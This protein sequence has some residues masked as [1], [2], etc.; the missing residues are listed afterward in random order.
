MRRPAA[1]ALA[2]ALLL[3]VGAASASP[4]A[5]PYA[6]EGINHMGVPQ[7][8]E[9]LFNQLMGAFTAMASGQD[10]VV[11]SAAPANVTPQAFAKM[12]GTILATVARSSYNT[13]SLGDP[14]MF[15]YPDGRVAL[16]RMPKY[17]KARCTCIF[18]HGC[19]HD[20]YSWFYKTPKCPQCTGLPEEV[21]HSKQCLAN[22]CAVLALMSLNRDYRSRCFASSGSGN[23]QPSAAQ[24][25]KYWASKAGMTKKPMYMF[26]ISSG[27][28]FAIKFPGTMKIQGVVSEVNMPW[29]KS[30]GATNGH[31]KLRYSFPPTV[32]YMMKRDLETK[33]QIEQ[34]LVIFKNNRV[35]ADY[36]Y[37]DS[38]P[39]TPDWLS[40]RSVYI[41]PSQSA[42]IQKYLYKIKVLDADGNVRYDVRV[43]RG[44]ILQ[45]P[46]YLPWLKRTDP[47]YNL[48]SDESQIWQELNLAWS[49]HEIVSDPV[50]A[51][52]KWLFAK[53]KADLGS[54]V[55]KYDWNQNIAC[56]SETRIGC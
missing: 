31:G 54:L 17:T 36:V 29:E 13:E 39:V 18:V 51:T 44:W 4:V 9:Q 56:L 45:L 46:K 25:V 5:T 43:K 50:T 14:K 2:A 28:S 40:M 10:A 6:P 23:D 11:A 20:P 8:Q 15:P 38:R 42:Q 19:K 35:P 1:A 26:G 3:V 22:G 27:A 12:A 16:Y 52:L 47:Y 55:K 34:A 53:G 37:I 41:S 21:S 33:R 24:L 7:G 32:F 49:W 30:W 48:I